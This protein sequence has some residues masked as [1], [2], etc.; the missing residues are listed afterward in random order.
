MVQRIYVMLVKR[1]SDALRLKLGGRPRTRL[2]KKTSSENDRPS[3]RSCLTW[4][5]RHES[6][7][8]DHIQT[9][10]SLRYLVRAKDGFRRS[11]LHV[12]CNFHEHVIQQ[13]ISTHETNR[14]TLAE[15]QSNRRSVPGLP[16]REQSVM[17]QGTNAYLE[18]HHFPLGRLHSCSRHGRLHQL[19]VLRAFNIRGVQHQGKSQKDV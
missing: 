16:D 19:G 2:R 3:R 1:S 17:A 11:L 5:M 18:L 14:R 15:V 13:V 4:S 9:F 7:K 12:T 6:E 10:E 8:T